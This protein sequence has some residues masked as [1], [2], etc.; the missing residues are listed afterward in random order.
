MKG[1]ENLRV[2]EDA[3]GVTIAVKVVPGSSRDRIA[4][5]LGD[6]LKITTAAPPEKGK[7][8]AAVRE[9]LAEALGADKRDVEL[10]AGQANP[11]K[12]LRVARMTAEG[13]RR[14]LAGLS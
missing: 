2:H 12:E 6:A 7:A 3:G 10:V 8:N 1:L 14:M 13:V 4:G 9:I 5:V 11:R